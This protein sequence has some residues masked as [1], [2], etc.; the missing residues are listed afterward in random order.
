M[1]ELEV[2]GIAAL[3]GFVVQTIVRLTP[4]KKDDEILK[5]AGPIK[6]IIWFLF[7]ASRKKK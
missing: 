4:T 2:T 6:K 1:S 7:E 5:E 3:V